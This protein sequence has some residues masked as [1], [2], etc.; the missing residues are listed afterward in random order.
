MITP[1]TGFYYCD[2]FLSNFGSKS[3]SKVKVE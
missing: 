3:K 1:I 2:F